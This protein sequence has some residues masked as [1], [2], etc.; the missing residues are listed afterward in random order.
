MVLIFSKFSNR[1]PLFYPDDKGFLGVDPG[2]T[3]TVFRSAYDHYNFLMDKVGREKLEGKSKFKPTAENLPLIYFCWHIMF[4]YFVLSINLSVLTDAILD[5]KKKTPIV[6]NSTG[7]LPVEIKFCPKSFVDAM[8]DQNMLGDIEIKPYVGPNA[9]LA[10]QDGQGFVSVTLN[11]YYHIRRDGKRIYLSQTADN[12]FGFFFLDF[13]SVLSAYWNWQTFVKKSADEFGKIIERAYS[14]FYKVFSQKATCV[15]EVVSLDLK[16]FHP[17]LIPSTEQAVKFYSQFRTPNKNLDTGQLVLKMFEHYR[18]TTP[19]NLTNYWG[20]LENLLYVYLDLI[21]GCYFYYFT[22]VNLSDEQLTF[23]SRNRDIMQYVLGLPRG[24]FFLWNIN[25]ELKVKDYYQNTE[26]YD[27]NKNPKLQGI[28]KKHPLYNT[29]EFDKY[30]YDSEMISDKERSDV[31]NFL[32]LMGK[33]HSCENQLK[34]LSDQPWEDRILP[35]FCFHLEDLDEKKEMP[36]NETLKNMT[37]DPRMEGRVTED[38]PYTML[39]RK[40]IHLFFFSDVFDNVS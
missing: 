7:V 30:L 39:L 9:A 3:Y 10:K 4:M 17:N 21:L 31:L 22:A 5:F 36:I 23:P 12:L 16:Q 2:R 33:I 13:V 11:I 28:D 20:G 15:Q 40:Y 25:L 29:P 34:H 32:K 1:I 35:I 18:D 37:A 8:V 6:P 14:Q 27:T 19:Y 26:Y 38:S 24:F